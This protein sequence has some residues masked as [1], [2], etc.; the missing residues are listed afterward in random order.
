MAKGSVE[1][2]IWGGLSSYTHTVSMRTRCIAS[3]R[4]LASG[5]GNVAGSGAAPPFSF[6][7]L[8]ACP[9]TYC[10]MRFL[11][12]SLGTVR[13]SAFGEVTS[14]L[15]TTSPYSGGPASRSKIVLINAS[16]LITLPGPTWSVRSIVP[17]RRMLTWPSGAKQW[18]YVSGAM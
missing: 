13:T 7:A 18:C 5:S 6:L 9:S 12:S 16:A 14:A 15:P 4:I 2:M 8:R 3:S 17:G 11:N 10:S 1:G